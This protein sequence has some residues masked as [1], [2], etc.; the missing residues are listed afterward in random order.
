[1]VTSA[2]A[3]SKAA[4]AMRLI[5]I[6]SAVGHNF[7]RVL[8]WLRALW[9]LILGTLIAAPSDCSPLKSVS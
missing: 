3:N 5:V 1:M 8:A 4:S 6:L 9:C 2:D 7:L